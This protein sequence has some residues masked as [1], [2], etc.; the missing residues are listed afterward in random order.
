MAF[1]LELAERI[2]MLN[3]GHVVVGATPAESSYDAEM[4]N[5]YHNDA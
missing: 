2:T 3:H 4:R 5:V 1:G